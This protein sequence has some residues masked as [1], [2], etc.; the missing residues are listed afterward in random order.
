MLSLSPFWFV[1]YAYWRCCTR[2]DAVV[3]QITEVLIG[4]S[5]YQNCLVFVELIIVFSKSKSENLHRERTPFPVSFHWFFVGFYLVPPMSEC[6]FPSGK[7]LFYYLIFMQEVAPCCW[8]CY[9]SSSCRKFC[10]W[11]TPTDSSKDR[12]NIDKKNLTSSR[13][14]CSKLGNYSNSLI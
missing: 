1:S 2:I 3:Q 11:V 4:H 8:P 14:S 10:S 9:Y 7:H 6:Q 13:M 5:G 12:T